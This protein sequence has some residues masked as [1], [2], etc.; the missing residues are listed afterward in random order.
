MNRHRTLPSHGDDRR[1][2][3]E[4]VYSKKSPG[5]VS[6][7]QATPEI[8][9]DL[10]RRT[11][12]PRDAAIVDV[13]GGASTFVDHLL[14]EGYS[15][16]HIL[17]ISGHA[18]SHARERLGAAAGRV[19]WIVADVTRW[20][21]D[22]SA[23][24]WHDRAVLHFLTDPDDQNAYADTLRTTLKPGGWA[25][26]AGFAPGGPRKCSGLDIVQ[27][28]ATSLQR[29]LGPEFRLVETRD[30]NHATPWGAPQAFRY[31]VFRKA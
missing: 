30:E 15:S 4:D 2:H 25:I 7:Y 12:L 21:P 10:V 17:D 22:V 5:E 6:W 13:G 3:W 27:H 11:G 28:D 24:L 31:H 26:I 9:L 18:L 1:T 29:L 19:G 8:S 16:L 20:R 14:R 23:D